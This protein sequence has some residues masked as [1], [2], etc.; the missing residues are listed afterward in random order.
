MDPFA[1]AD[2]S[3]RSGLCP[4]RAIR[5][6]RALA[7]ASADHRPHPEDVIGSRSCRISQ[8]RGRW[9]RIVRR[10]PSVRCERGS[11]ADPEGGPRVPVAE[12]SAVRGRER[13]FTVLVSPGARAASGFSSIGRFAASRR[14][15]DRRA[16]LCRRAERLC[17]I[18]RLE[19]FGEE[20]CSLRSGLGMNGVEPGSSGLASELEPYCGDGAVRSDALAVTGPTERTIELMGPRVRALRASSFSPS[21]S[22]EGEARPS[23]VQPRGLDASSSAFSL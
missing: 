14:G 1:P 11:R 7:T 12:R 17:S 5:L 18:E 9:P 15:S 13:F 8:S 21:P 4:V 6:F 19:R 16:D 22:A 10:A 23:A 2:R 3:T 20:R